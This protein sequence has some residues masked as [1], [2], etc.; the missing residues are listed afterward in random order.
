MDK[1]P[2]EK[3]FFVLKVDV[4]NEHDRIYS[5]SLVNEWIQK[6]EET[7]KGYS[8]EFAVNLNEKN[9]KTEFIKDSL[10]CGMVTELKIVALDT[11]EKILIAKAKFKIKGPYSDKMYESGFFDNMTLV[12]KGC[13]KVWDNKIY[14]YRLIGFNLVPMELS[15]FISSEEEE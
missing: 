2:I 1:K 15:P 13:G 10:N 5:E 8:I 14:D 4:V 9:L 6:L 11:K 7:K 3:E 12:P